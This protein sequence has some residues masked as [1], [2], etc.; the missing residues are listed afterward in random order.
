[1]NRQVKRDL[2]GRGRPLQRRPSK[3]YAVKRLSPPR[4]RGRR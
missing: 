2:Y 3:R 1:M 4:R